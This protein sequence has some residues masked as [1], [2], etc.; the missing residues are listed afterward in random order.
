MTTPRGIPELPTGQNAAPETINEQTRYNEQ[1]ASFYVV[2]DKDLATPP[3]SP[4]D[5][6]C[7]VV[8]SSPTGAWTGQTGKLAFYLSTAWAFR[9]PIEGYYAYLQ[10]EN[11]LYS[12]DGAAWGTATGT[13]SNEQA[14]DAVGT[15]LTDTATIDFTYNDGANTIT[16]DVV[17]AALKPPE[18]IIIAC[19]DESSSISA[20]TNKVKFRMPYAFTVTAV[21]A[22]LTTAQATGSIFTVDINESGTTILSTKLTI[23]NTEKT[24]TT[25]ATPPVISD[26]S[27]ADD[28][29]MSID[30]DQI[31]D[32]TATGLK[33]TLIGNRT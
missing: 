14:Q 33:V 24:S 4:A 31:G 25:A 19:G 7:Y 27:L 8:A 1:G 11:T 26:S 6:D 21:R 3:G 20:G 22:S 5:G 18:S 10:D 28:A 2:K 9:T 30:V 13:Y 29:E 15:I 23:D 12:Y 16:A 32:A 17:Q